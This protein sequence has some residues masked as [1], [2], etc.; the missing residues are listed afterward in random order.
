MAGSGFGT[1]E[2]GGR[3]AD[4]VGCSSVGVSWRAV[5]CRLGWVGVGGAIAT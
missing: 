3:H 1:L 4:T 2:I 5:G